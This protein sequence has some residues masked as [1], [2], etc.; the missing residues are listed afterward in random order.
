VHRIGQPVGSMPNGQWLH[1]LAIE[2]ETN[3]LPQILAT[4]RLITSIN[5]YRRDV[6]YDDCGRQGML[7]SGRRKF[8]PPI[9]SIIV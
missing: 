9:S 5:D 2:T 7:Y 1:N 3:Q 6:V 8:G 4:Q